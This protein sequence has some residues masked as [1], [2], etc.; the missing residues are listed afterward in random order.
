MSKQQTSEPTTDRRAIVLGILAQTAMPLTRHEIFDRAT[1]EVFDKKNPSFG[2]NQVS[3]VLS[4][5]KADGLILDEEEP[6]NKLK[7]WRLADPVPTQAEAAAEP[8]AT[9]FDEPSSP[10][11][12]IAE[13]H[14]AGHHVQVWVCTVDEAG[15]LDPV[16]VAEETPASY[17]VEEEEHPDSFSDVPEPAG[18]LPPEASETQSHGIEPASSVG[19]LSEFSPSPTTA[20][21]ELPADY[22]EP[23]RRLRAKLYQPPIQHLV[24]KRALLEGL[25][26]TLKGQLPTEHIATLL[27]IHDDLNRHANPGA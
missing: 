6:L 1:G 26:E 12:A 19:C 22:L 18:T 8:E 10:S 15:D 2:R 24:K 27:A 23:L 4:K 13:E 7:T 20:D 17:H 11:T 9:P 21:P 14:P 5:L 16:A 25:A 3:A